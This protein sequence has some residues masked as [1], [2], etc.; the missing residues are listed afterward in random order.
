MF[1]GGFLIRILH[2]EIVGMLRL[3]VIA[4]LIACVLGLSYLAACPETQLAG[5]EVTYPNER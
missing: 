2:L 1:L 3:N 5:L 4:T